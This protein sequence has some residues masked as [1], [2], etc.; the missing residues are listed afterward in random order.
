MVE[1]KKTKRSEIHEPSRDY[2]SVYANHINVAITPWDMRLR[3]SQIEDA[4]EETITFKDVATIFLSPGQAK[5][6]R[7]VL[8]DKAAQHESVWAQQDSIIAS[9]G[10]EK[11]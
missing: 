4:T 3:F 10:E 11:K 9:L 2:V 5:A 1:E 7:K 8:N 6:L